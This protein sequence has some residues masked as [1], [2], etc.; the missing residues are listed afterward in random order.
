MASIAFS[1]S[2]LAQSTLLE[3]VKSD[4]K[5]SLALCQKFRSLN[6]KGISASSKE[7]INEISRQKNLSTTDSEILSIYVI[8][9]HCPDVN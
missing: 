5:E 8:G 6:S 9:L 1:Q 4:P 2:V 7:A 3:K